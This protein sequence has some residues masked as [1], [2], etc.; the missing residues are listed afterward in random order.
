MKKKILIIEDDV[1]ISSSIEELLID[2]GYEVATAK[3]GQD[4]LDQLQSM[5]SLPQLILLDLMMPVKDGIGFREDQAKD[6]RINEIP[7]ILMSADAQIEAKKIK[8]GIAQHLKKP[9]DIDV[10]LKLIDSLIL[11]GF[12][13]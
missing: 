9:L 3:N 6:S 4:A 5:N 12:R 13:V 2:E 8:M 1:E 7:V 10:L 11:P